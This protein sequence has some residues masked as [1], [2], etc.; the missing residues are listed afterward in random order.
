MPISVQNRTYE[1]QL[2]KS[3]P[4]WKIRLSKPIGP[5]GASGAFP[6]PKALH[7]AEVGMKRRSPADHP[8]A[9]R[10]RGPSEIRPTDRSDW[11]GSVVNVVELTCTDTGAALIAKSSTPYVSVTY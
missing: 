2:R 8:S 4:L 7:T 11:G 6:A 10:C 1:T 3:P 5:Y 9:V